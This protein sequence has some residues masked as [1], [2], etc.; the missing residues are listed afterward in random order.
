MDSSGPEPSAETSQPAGG[1]GRGEAW[2]FGL[3]FGA[4]SFLQGIG[5]PTEG[6]IAQPV[7]SLLKSWGRDASE[8][9]A[10]SA[11]L[12]VPWSLKPLYGLLSDFVPLAGSRRRSYLVV[13]SS[14]TAVSL[15]GLS[16]FPVPRG[17]TSAL[18][19]WLLLPTVAA[20]FS[21]VVTDALMVEQ[22]QPRGLTGRIQVVQWA[23]LY[24]A[25]IVTGMVGG[26]L[27]QHHREPWSFLICGAGAVLTLG[28][29]LGVV[30]EP[31]R[32]GDAR[33]TFQALKALGDA[34]RS[35][36]LIGVGGF[37]LLWNF[38]PFSHV[39]LYVH[40][41]RELRWS[42]RFFGQTVA[43]TALA[44]IAASLSYGLYDRR[45]PFRVLAHASIALGVLS[46]LAYLAMTDERSAVLVTLA[47][48]F[49]YMTATLI[50]LDLAARSCPPE[51]AGTVFATL[52]ALENLAA[53]LSAWLGGH[54]YEQGLA[55]WGGRTSF[56]VLVLVGAA[57]T[58]ACWLL[59]PL[60]P[61]DFA[62]PRSPRRGA[63]REGSGSHCQSN[64]A[65]SI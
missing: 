26:L 42:E 31:A 41:T 27:C 35:P 22:G 38:N 25:G 18:L 40:M 7:R 47:V 61:R 16:L 36:A 2:R 5:E 60:L 28:L 9:A 45:V 29:A 11:L 4:I 21:D 3:L 53:S 14:L 12:V 1:S 32:A 19:A 59:V 62:P 44:S 63:S 13:A 34:A 55:R 52:M 24:G 10:F 64:F 6:L 54:W 39:I 48:G 37:L 65:D 23:C 15:V 30:R 46:S 8:I 57:F 49:T 50:Q 17:A 33:E 58:A 51:A 43:L 56:R 20:A